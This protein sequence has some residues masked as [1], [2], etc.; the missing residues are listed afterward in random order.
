[1][2]KLLWFCINCRY[3]IEK[4]SLPETLS[5]IFGGDRDKPI[6]IE[7]KKNC[8]K[9]GSPMIEVKDTDE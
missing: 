7:T 3:S 9:C 2:N 4:P 6:Y 8:P 1:M 5:E